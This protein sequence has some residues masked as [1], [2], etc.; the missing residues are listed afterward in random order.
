MLSKEEILKNLSKY[1]TR[2]KPVTIH[3]SLK[4]IGEI[5]G[6]AETLLSALKESFANDG[7]L[8]VIPTHTWDD[9]T[10]DLRNPRTCI[11]VLPTIAV[12]QKDAVR[13]HHPSH[14]VTVFGDRQ[15][16]LDFVKNDG[17][18]DTPTSPFGC[19]GKLYDEDGYVFLIGVGQEKNTFIHCVE[20]MMEYPRY[21]KEKVSAKFIDE[22]GRETKRSIYWF[23]ETK[24]ADVSEYFGKFEAAF[25]YYKCIEYSNLGNA[26]TQMIKARDIKRVIENIYKNA[27]GRELLADH[28]P[29]DINLYQ[30]K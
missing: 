28:K 16:A 27:C 11:G 7:G 2:G 18:T 19:Y 6:G 9:R 20:E 30:Q 25:D 13:S 4:A 22:N 26:K 1:N 15:K 29:L 8:L 12:G 24:I 14:S 5:E 3:C 21:L 10:L 23:D 17:A